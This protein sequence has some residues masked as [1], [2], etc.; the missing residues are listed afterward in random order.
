VIGRLDPATVEVFA[1]GLGA[2]LVDSPPPVALLVQP[3][4]MI[5]VRAVATAEERIST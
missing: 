2:A 3:T 1:G 5:A 4:S